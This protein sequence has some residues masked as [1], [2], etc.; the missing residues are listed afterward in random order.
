MAMTLPNLLTPDQSH[1]ILALADPL[2][3][4]TACHLTVQNVLEHE[5]YQQTTLM[6]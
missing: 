4:M 3:T 5:P 1:R 2:A 6:D